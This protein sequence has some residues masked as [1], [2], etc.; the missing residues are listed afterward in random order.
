MRGEVSQQCHVHV[1]ATACYSR[2]QQAAVGCAVPVGRAV[3]APLRKSLS[4]IG[5]Q[6][7]RLFCPGTILALACG[8]T[9]D[10]GGYAICT[11]ERAE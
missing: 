8:I 7:V 3:Y 5:A 9:A 4:C 6:T 11:Y 2:L 1:P 10:A